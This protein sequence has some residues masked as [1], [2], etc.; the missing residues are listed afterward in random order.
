MDKHDDRIEAIGTIDELNAALG[1][2]ASFSANKTSKLIIQEV[3]NDMFT[4]GAELANTAKVGIEEKHVKNT[5]K[6]I[7]KL[8]QQLPAQSKFIIPQGT[9]AAMM[10]NMSRAIARR[11]ER[12]LVKLDRK[13]KLNEQLLKYSNRLSS[14]LY[15]L[16]RYENQQSSIKEKNPV[17]NYKNEANSLRS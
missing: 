8:Q 16:M 17:Y 12:V 3:Q 1:A 7:D 2:A 13:S 9:Q 11:A 14:L 5:E 10:L 6:L 15:M 4:I